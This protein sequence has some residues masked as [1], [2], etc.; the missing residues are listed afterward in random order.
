ME[1]PTTELTLEEITDKLLKNNIITEKQLELIYNMSLTD[2]MCSLE[3][4]VFD[5][6]LYPIPHYNMLM[7]TSILM[8]IYLSKFENLNKT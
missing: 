5:R 1:N 7:V 8:N 3:N 4:D 6:Y 2:G